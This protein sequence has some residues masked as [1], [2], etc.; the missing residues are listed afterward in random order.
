VTIPNLLQRSTPN[1]P[2]DLDP[3]Y[4]AVSLSV[5]WTWEHRGTHEV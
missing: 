2:P 3:N 5:Q 4:L 1:K